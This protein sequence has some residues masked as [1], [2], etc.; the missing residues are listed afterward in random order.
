[1]QDAKSLFQQLRMF[2]VKNEAW[3]I[4]PKSYQEYLFEM[5][6]DEK[7]FS[8]GDLVEHDVSGLT[9]KVHR[10]GANHIICLTEEGVC[11]KSFVHQLSH[12]N[13]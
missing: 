1:M 10:C 3:E 6:K 7:L 4:D 8:K 11:F 5:Y 13:T 9:G 2:M 12:L